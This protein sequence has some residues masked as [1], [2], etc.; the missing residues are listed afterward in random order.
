MSLTKQ[1]PTVEISTAELEALRQKIEELRQERDD[2]AMMLELNTKH[3]DIVGKELHNRAE[4]AIR[5]SERRLRLIVE[6]TP[7]ALIISRLSDSKIVY[8]NEMAGPQVG[9]TP[10][11]LIGHQVTELFK[12]PS[13]LEEMLTQLEEVEQISNFNIEIKGVDGTIMWMDASISKLIFNDEPSM[14][15]AWHD[16]TYLVEMNKAAN[17][18]VPNEYLN[19]LQKKSIVDINLGDYACREMTIMFSD[20][21]SF[22]TISENMTAVENFAFINS[23]LG[24]VSPIIREHNGFIVKYIGDGIHAIFT[25]SADDCLQSCIRQLERLNEYNVYRLEKGRLPIQIGIGVN[26]GYMMVGMVGETH[27]VQG[28]AFSNDVNLTARVEGLTKFYNV[29]F[30]ITAAT[31]KRLH[32]PSQYSIRFLDKVQVKGKSTALDLYEVYQADT[33]EQHELKRETQ[34]DY[35]EAMRLYYVQDFA[36]AQA[37][38]FKVLQRNPADKVAWHHL[39]KATQAIDEGVSENWTGVTVMT[40]K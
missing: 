39:I 12:D 10:E 17:R 24:K 1:D 20:L 26:T 8:A 29:S 5:E 4:E 35:E 18:F 27:R 40:K 3:S 2:L 32:N 30:I 7:V 11:E 31:Y 33:T 14:L 25:E 9:L 21:R 6:A 34:I 36:G 23:Y 13:Q 22:T 38:L 37:N 19:F 28:D 15:S 16:I